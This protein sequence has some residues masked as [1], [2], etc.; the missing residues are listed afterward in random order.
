VPA[1][2]AVSVVLESRLWLAE[3]L[4]CFESEEGRE[5]WLEVRHVLP[6]APAAVGRGADEEARQGVQAGGVRAW[7]EVSRR[8]VEALRCQPMGIWVEGDRE[9][10]KVMQ[11][12][13]VKLGEIS[14]PEEASRVAETAIR[15]AERHNQQAAESIQRRLAETDQ[16]LQR[17][18]AILGALLQHSPSPATASRIGTLIDS[19]HRIRG[20]GCGVSLPEVERSPLR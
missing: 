10:D 6:S 18:L 17:V 19:I 15:T 20:L 5:L 8:L 1:D 4:A 14:G 12:L 2:A 11:A 3:A 16:L 9:F 7:A 13:A